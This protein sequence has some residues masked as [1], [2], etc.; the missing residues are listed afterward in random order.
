MQHLH[1]RAQTLYATALQEADWDPDRILQ[2]FGWTRAELNAAER[3]LADLNLFAPS[4]GTPSG[5]TVLS[6]E[7]AEYG[8]LSKSARRSMAI[9]EEAARVREALEVLHSDARRIHRQQSSGAQLRVVSG[10]ENVAAA[11]DEAAHHARQRVWSMHPGRALPEESLVAGLARDTQVLARDVEVRTMHLA[12]TTVV[13][14]MSVYLN[15]LAYAGAQVR[16]LQTLPL[17]MILIDHQ[18]AFLPAPATGNADAPSVLLVRSPE[19]VHVMEL[20][21]EHIWGL[22]VQLRDGITE[23]EAT[24]AWRPTPRHKEL[25]RMLAAGL[26]DDTIS[27]KLGVSQRTIRRLVAELLEQLGAESRFQAGV[28]AIRRGWLAD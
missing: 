14:H 20:L 4:D 23:D 19:I 3:N 16:T 15:R 18:Q 2:E 1:E 9:L 27:R 7:A 12:S 5:W 26:T 13:P 25:L 8:L 28:N 11:L 22:S 17:R 24:A 6:P 10:T 21:Y